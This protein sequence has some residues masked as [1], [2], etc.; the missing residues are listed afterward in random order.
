MGVVDT[1]KL[2]RCPADTL[3]ID[4]TL[5]AQI[6]TDAN[7][8]MLVEHIIELSARFN[9]LTVAV[10][11]ESEKQRSLL[12]KLGCSHAQGFLFT[13]PI[14]LADFPGFLQNQRGDKPSR[15]IV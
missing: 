3:K 15:E 9:L 6:E 2:L 4:R 8:L 13:A 5:I 14:P 11:V 7:A 10:G 1:E 12:A